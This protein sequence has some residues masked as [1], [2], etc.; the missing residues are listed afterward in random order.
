MPF[1]PLYSDVEILLCLGLCPEIFP[2]KPSQAT[3]TALFLF[4]Q[5]CVLTSYMMV[6]ASGPF[7]LL[8]FEPLEDRQL[9]YYL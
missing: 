8:D 9:L 1:S 3:L 7:A 6:G 2:A 5:Y 4:L